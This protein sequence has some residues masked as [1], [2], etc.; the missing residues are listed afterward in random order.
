MADEPTDHRHPPRRA[1]RGFRVDRG[2]ERHRPTDRRA[3]G[4]RLRRPD[5]VP[6]G[7]VGAGHSGKWIRLIGE[8]GPASR[9]DAVAGAA[10]AGPDGTAHGWWATGVPE[11]DA[12]GPSRPCK[13][14]AGRWKVPSLGSAAV[15]SG[16]LASGDF[17]PV[18]L[19]RVSDGG[20]VMIRDI[21]HVGEVTPYVT[22]GYRCDGSG[23]DRHRG[24][25]QV[26]GHDAW[27]NWRGRAG[28]SVRTAGA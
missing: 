20:S 19:R 11:T 1:R 13:R 14:T 22:V 25:A 5:A 16:L 15:G 9:G 24:W 8:C 2:R 17:C 6:S 7:A 3:T 26:A 28:R 27:E 4:V 12:N 21:P 18:T 23:A 10:G